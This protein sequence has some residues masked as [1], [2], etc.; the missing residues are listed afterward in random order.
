[1]ISFFYHHVI[2]CCAMNDLAYEQ[3]KACVE[4]FLILLLGANNQPVPSIVHLDK[5]LF[6]LTE[7]VPR[8][9]NC[10]KFSSSSNGPHSEIAYKA[11]GDSSEFNKGSFNSFY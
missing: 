6:V 10:I 5:E 8:I 11:I 9:G 4:K 1:M 7:A 2:G 3:E